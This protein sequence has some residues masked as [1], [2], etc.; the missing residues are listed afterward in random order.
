[1][2]STNVNRVR[3]MPLETSQNGSHLPDGKANDESNDSNDKEQKEAELLVLPPHLPLELASTCLE[4]LGLYSI[5]LEQLNKNK[6][7]ISDLRLE[8][9]SLVHENVELL[10]TLQ[11]LF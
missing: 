8:I 6:N 9:L 7:L 3:D 10:T 4:S 1:M 5:A 11:Y 2:S